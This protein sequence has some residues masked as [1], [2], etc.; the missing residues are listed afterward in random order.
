MTKYILA[1][2]ELIE[3]PNINQIDRLQA[4]KRYTEK[5]EE[6]F[7]AYCYNYILTKK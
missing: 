5:L 4:L 7:H 3:T 2:E 6:M 1:F